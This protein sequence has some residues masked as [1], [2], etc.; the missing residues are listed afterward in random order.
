MSDTSFLGYY[1]TVRKGRTSGG[2]HRCILTRLWR[3]CLPHW[4]QKSCSLCS[5]PLRIRSS[6]SKA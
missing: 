1:T 5:T 6:I 3:A 4:A 2:E